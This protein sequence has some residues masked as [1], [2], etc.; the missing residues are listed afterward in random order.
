MY[1]TIITQ[2]N[3]LSVLGVGKSLKAGEIYYVEEQKIKKDSNPKN[4][5]YRSDVKF[6]IRGIKNPVSTY[7]FE[8][9]DIKEQRNIKLKNL[10]GDKIKTGEQTRKFLLYTEKEKIQ[11]LFET[12][13]RVLSD[14]AKIEINEKPN[15]IRL[16]LIKGNK[17]A[18]I[19]DD[20]KFFLKEKIE[21]ILKPF[22]K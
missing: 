6:K 18:L 21:T 22:E 5:Y 10:K 1:F 12:L 3:L 4:G 17:Y 14:L 16:M 7:K 11:I 13:T 20:I 8:E 19:E 9:I 2:V 15:L